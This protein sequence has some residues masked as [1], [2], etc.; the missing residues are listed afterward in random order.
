[1]TLVDRLGRTP[2]HFAITEA[3]Q[4]SRNHEESV[5]I[6]CRYPVVQLSFVYGILLQEGSEEK[7]RSRRVDLAVEG[8]AS[9][10]VSS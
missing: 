1:V 10:F 4:G 7:I 5:V 8:F 2:F 3:H 6:P 9:D